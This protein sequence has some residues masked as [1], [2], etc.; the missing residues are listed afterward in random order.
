MRQLLTQLQIVV[1][2]CNGYTKE[3]I[4]ST[5]GLHVQTVRTR[6][7]EAG[8]NTEGSRAALSP[9]DKNTLQELH[10]RGQS[11]RQLARR[12]SV[13]HTT[14]LRVLERSA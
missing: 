10:R 13:A 6:L 3:Q 2:Y 1:A 5:Y 4:A 14:V 7:R 12:Y 9:Q 11:A 8:V